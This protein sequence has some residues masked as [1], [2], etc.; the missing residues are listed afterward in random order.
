M[1]LAVPGSDDEGPAE[2]GVAAVPPARLDGHAP[3]VGV[4][5]GELLL[6]HLGPCSMKPPGLDLSVESVYF[7][8]TFETLLTGATSA[9]APATRANAATVRAIVTTPALT[10]G[11]G[12]V[13]VSRPQ[14]VRPPS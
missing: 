11:R 3:A 12:A 2:H 14:R 7:S 9:L 10:E 1:R 8:T 6:E 5:L 4:E 13:R